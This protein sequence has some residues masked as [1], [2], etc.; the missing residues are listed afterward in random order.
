M[1]TFSENKIKELNAIPLRDSK[2]WKRS[3]FKKLKGRQVYWEWKQKV[4][5]I[6][7]VCPI[8]CNIWFTEHFNGWSDTTNATSE[9][10]LIP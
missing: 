7:H 4:Y 9:M 1:N 6:K 8:T 10:W 2:E 3:N 5:T